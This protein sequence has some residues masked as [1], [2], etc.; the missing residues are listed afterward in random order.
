MDG[1]ISPNCKRRYKDPRTA[2]LVGI[3][4]V[5]RDLR[6]A[7]LVQI[8]KGDEGIHGPPIWSEFL[9]GDE[10]IQGPPIWFKLLKGMKGS[11][12][13]RFGQNF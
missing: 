5:D 10:G 7:D 11:T 9:K 2:D 3:F 13:R 4:K 6:T 12:D 8:F 1:R